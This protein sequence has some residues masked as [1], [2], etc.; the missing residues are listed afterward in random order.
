MRKRAGIYL[1]VSTDGQTT[2][3]QRRE[4]EAVAA[5]SG[6]EVVAVYEDAGISGSNGRDKRPGL[7]RLLNDATARKINMIAAW[8]V[9]RLGRSLQHLVSF[10]NEL[11]ALNCNL[12]LHQQAIDTTTPS[13]RA[14]FQMCG[15]FAEFERSMI[16]ERVNAGLARARAN[17]V[18]L[19]RGNR[20]DDQRSADE[21][22][23][24]MSRA[25]VECASSASGSRVWA[26]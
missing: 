16:V 20:K 22:R 2:Q 11:Q 19:G 12:Y 26:S 14:M 9:D 8:S 13:G 18:R 23:W 15:V 17:G 3:N 1:R 7:D 4:I 25:E 21:R 10:L 24:G 5:R 6:W